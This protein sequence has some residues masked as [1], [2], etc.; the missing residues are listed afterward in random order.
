MKY[1][2]AGGR[3]FIRSHIAGVLL[4][5]TDEV[6]VIDHLSTGSIENIAHLKGRKG[7][8]CFFESVFSHPVPS[9]SHGHQMRMSSREVSS[10]GGLGEKLSLE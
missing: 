3:G 8:S 5:R 2:L 1:I 9:R 4:S 6:A 7:F 10:K